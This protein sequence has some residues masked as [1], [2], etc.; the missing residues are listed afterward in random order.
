MPKDID[1][2]NSTGTFQQNDVLFSH[3]EVV[4]FNNIK[5]IKMQVK[6][7]RGIIMTTL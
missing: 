4:Y 7:N 6:Y 1:G 2:N 5:V 3:L